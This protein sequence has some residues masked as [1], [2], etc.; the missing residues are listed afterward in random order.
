MQIS[1]SIDPCPLFPHRHAD[2]GHASAG[3]ASNAGQRASAVL[4]RFLHFRHRR[5]AAL[6]WHPQTEVLHRALTQ[7][8]VARVS[9]PN[10]F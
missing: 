1:I 6:G 10:S 7:H 4:L 9:V 2:P 8:F 5:G 3:H